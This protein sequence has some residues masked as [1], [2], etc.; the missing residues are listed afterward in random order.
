M[1]IL[2]ERQSVPDCFSSFILPPIQDPIKSK[3]KY[4]LYQGYGK[5]KGLSFAAVNYLEQIILSLDFSL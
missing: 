4:Q 3:T 2:F 1:T 5:A